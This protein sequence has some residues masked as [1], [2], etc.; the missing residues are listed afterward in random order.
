MNGGK[1][2]TRPWG[3]F[4]VI[5]EEDNYKVKRIN[6]KPKQRLSLQYHHHRDEVWVIVQGTGIITRG[7]DEIKCSKG[8]FVS[9]PS[10]AKHRVE[11]TGSEDLI[12]IE[13]QNGSYLGEDDIVRLQDDYNR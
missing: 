10:K 11:N 7:D 4:E 3:S 2:E 12:F 1:G 5:L 6:V 13:V 9:I 8:D